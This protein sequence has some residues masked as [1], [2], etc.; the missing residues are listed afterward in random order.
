MGK[1][2]NEEAPTIDTEEN[3]PSSQVAD[4]NI[5]FEKTPDIG[6]KLTPRTHRFI[7]TFSRDGGFFEAPRLVK[8]NRPYNQSLNVLN[9]KNKYGKHKWTLLGNLF[10]NDWFHIIMR[11]PTIISLIFILSLWIGFIMIFAGI[12]MAI[13]ARDPSVSCGLG[14]ENNPIQIWGAFAFSLETCTTVGYGLPGDTMGFF[15]NCPDLQVA[16]FFQMMFSMCF[17][18]FLLSFLFTRIARCEAR[19]AQLLFTDKAVVRRD[20]R[21]RLLFEVKVYDADSKYPLV[22]SHVRLYA[23]H[24]SSNRNYNPLRT[25]IPND[26]LGGTLLTSIPS[27]IVHHIDAYSQLLPPKFRYHKKM[28]DGCGMALREI[29]SE[30]CSRDGVICPICGESYGTYDRLRTHIRFNQVQEK[31]SEFPVEGTHQELTEK[32]VSLLT[33]PE[34]HYPAPTFDELKMFFERSKIEVVAVVEGIDPLTSGTFSALHS[35]QSED[36]ELE[37][38]F[39]SCWDSDNQVDLELFHETVST[40]AKLNMRSS[41]GQYL[42]NQKDVS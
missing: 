9:V 42:S 6:E 12:Y 24:S 11:W 41:N 17:N 18:A 23:V 16:I 8:R 32:E 26:D 38:E 15:E 5:D 27:T 7:N 1:V 40:R 28:I 21:G 3:S 37:R 13:D 30:T 35:Y 39:V 22:E 36:I 20:S 29:D 4:I 19:G 33:E 2:K 31:Y 34:K 14:F 10:Y 25:M